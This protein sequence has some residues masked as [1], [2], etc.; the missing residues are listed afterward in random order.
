MVVALTMFGAWLFLRVSKAPLEITKTSPVNGAT[1]NP[2][3][4]DVIF[5]FSENIDTESKPFT[6]VV[7]H[8][9]YQIDIKGQ[10]IVFRFENDFQDRS[11]YNLIIENVRG[12]SGAKLNIAA[13]TF[14]VNDNSPLGAFKRTLPR[15]SDRFSLKHN[16]NNE[17]YVIV[18]ARD[19]NGVKAS[20]E[21]IFR[22]AG[23]NPEDYVISYDTNT[24]A[25][26]GGE[27]L[28]HE[29]DVI[30]DGP[31]EDHEH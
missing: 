28:P 13:L 22:S 27:P 18:W 11:A 14:T 23:L 5:S 29:Y 19:F 7:P 31:E 25:F 30:E 17:F 6:V 2:N 8:A 16:K 12:V 15:D 9:N 26:S 24:S 1:I 10:D 20:V 3:H 4:R 21:E